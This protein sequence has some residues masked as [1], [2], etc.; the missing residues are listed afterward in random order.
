[1]KADQQKREPIAASPEPAAAMRAERVAACAAEVNAVLEK[2]KCRLLAVV[3]IAGGQV[4]ESGDF[5][6][7]FE[8]LVADGVKLFADAFEQFVRPSILKMSGH[9]NLFRP[10]LQA[11]L[12]EDLSKKAGLVHFI[13][14]H[15]F[16]KGG[17]INFPVISG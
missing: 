11:V 2:H 6:E 12:R 1:M 4:Q 16:L 8:K 17:C 14:C 5:F 13:R 7:R 3:V 9:R 15:L 10:T